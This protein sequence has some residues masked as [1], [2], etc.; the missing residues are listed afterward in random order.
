MEG[1]M[2]A[3]YITDADVMKD[4]N[5]ELTALSMALDRSQE[6]LLERGLSMPEHLSL[7]YGN[8]ARE[9]K[10]QHTAKWMAWLVASGKLR[11]V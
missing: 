10:A 5:L 9:G 8:N 11:S 2:E 3:Y 4:S 1:V 6:I 7:T